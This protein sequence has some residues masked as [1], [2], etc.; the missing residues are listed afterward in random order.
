MGIGNL[1]RRLTTK[2]PAG[3]EFYSGDYHSGHMNCVYIPDGENKVFDG[4]F[5]YEHLFDG[6]G[7][8][9]AKG[10]YDHNRKDGDWVFELQ[11][12]SKTRRLYAQF[13]QGIVHGELEFECKEGGFLK[14]VTT[15]LGM[16]V[17]DS[18]IKGK[19][20]GTMNGG[21]I[22]GYC[23]EQGRP[24][25]KWKLTYAEED[26][27]AKALVEVWDHGV[28]T[29]SYEETLGKYGKKSKKPVGLLN[30]LNYIL[31]EDCLPL[32]FMVQR[33]TKTNHLQIIVEKK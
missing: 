14:S 13:D 7:Y 24:E 10:Q 25:G 2:V 22:V 28:M 33:G 5:E 17:E 21:E 18:V 31:D 27:T 11:G 16:S 23:D 1:F 19:F 26:G 12:H 4:P 29:D 30:R 6:G 9:K 8:E 15:S 32:L 3:H 20:V